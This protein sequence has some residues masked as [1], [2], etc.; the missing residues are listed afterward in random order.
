[1]PLPRGGGGIAARP[2][3]A[4]AR[5]R[6]S[7][8]P[9]SVRRTG[10]SGPPHVVAEA[11]A[12]P[13]RGRRRC[14]SSTPRRHAE[15]R[16]PVR[17]QT[18]P[19]AT[20]TSNARRRAAASEAPRG[21]RPR[22]RVSSSGPP[23]SGVPTGTGHGGDWYLAS[24]QQK[25]WMIWNQQIKTGYTQ[26]VGVTF[27]IL[28]DGSIADVRVTQPSGA[29]LLDLAAQRAVTSTRRRSVRSRRTMEPNR[30]T[31]QAVFKPTSELALAG[32][33]G[34][35]SSMVVARERAASRPRPPAQAPGHARPSSSAACRRPSSPCPT[36]SPGSGR[37]GERPAC[38]T[39][40]EVLRADLRFEN[41]FQF[42][43]DSLIQAIPPLNPQAP[44][45]EDWKGIGANILV[46]TPAEVTG[47]E[48]TSRRKAYFVDSGQ[49]DARASATRA[50][51]Q[52]AGLRA[53]GLG[54][55]HGAHAVQR[56]RADADRLRAPTATR[57]RSAGEGAL[58]RRLRRLQPA[59]ASR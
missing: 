9:G 44:K 40:A 31:I 39:V 17:A 5:A 48:L 6:R 18:D 23:G 42:V 49:V 19:C 51:R 54:R 14:R 55:H 25:I 52:P 57:R 38:S 45:F 20:A 7:R 21:L 28:P 12:R 33:R 13:S 50:A 29:T 46:V 59:P 32:P 10:R 35:A 43:P 41:L 37:R 4:R 53:P 24:V 8:R 16:P 56:R 22:R 26:S 47:G 58:H 36:A 27:T 3:A 1:M 30:N 11:A 15:D 2:G 34:A